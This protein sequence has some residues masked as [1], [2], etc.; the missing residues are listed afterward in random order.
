MFQCQSL[1]T[2]EPSVPTDVIYC[3]EILLQDLQRGSPDDTCE[4]TTNVL[5]VKDVRAV[6]LGDYNTCLN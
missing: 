4:A 6:Q 2:M 3:D 1:I 5:S